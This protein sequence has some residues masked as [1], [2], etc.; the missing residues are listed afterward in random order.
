MGSIVVNIQRKASRYIL[1]GCLFTPITE[2]F[3]WEMIAD[4]L[5][6]MAFVHNNNFYII[7][8]M[9]DKKIFCENGTKALQTCWV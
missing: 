5:K 6:T 4:I 7:V 2:I 9:Y 3:Q 1:K 8:I